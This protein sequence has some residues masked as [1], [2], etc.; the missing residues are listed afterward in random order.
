MKKMNVALAILVTAVMAGNAQTTATS[1]IVGY[2][3]IT[4]PVG[5]STAGFP[6]LNSDVVK[7]ATT[8]LVGNALGLQSQSNVGALL[9]STEPYYIEVYSGALK[10]D[11]FDVDVAA[12]IA[13]ANGNVVITDCP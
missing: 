2:Q 3:T 6:L 11:R 12:K 4:V 9:T 7:G 5:L 8:T 13:A 1:D 10:G